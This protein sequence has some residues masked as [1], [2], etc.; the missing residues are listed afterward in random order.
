MNTV[1]PAVRVENLSRSFGKVHVLK[2]VDFELDRGKIY[3]IMGP[4]GCGKTTLLKSMIGAQ[5]PSAG[6]VFIDGIDIWNDKK[7]LGKARR[8]FG[9]LFQSGALLNGLTCYDNVALPLRQHTNLDPETIDIMVRMKLELVGMGHAADRRP[10]EISG[11]MQKRCA[12]AR[13]IAL[14]PAIVFFDEPSAGI[15]PVMISIL[16]RLVL[17]LTE[18]LGITSVV[19]THEIPSAFRIA[20]EILMMYQGKLHFRGKPEAV[21]HSR[22]PVVRQFIHGDSEGPMSQ[23]SSRQAVA[24]RVLGMP[25]H[26]APIPAHI[27]QR[28]TGRVQKSDERFSQAHDAIFD[29]QDDTRAKRT[30]RLPQAPDPARETEK[31]T[32]KAVPANSEKQSDNITRKIN[33]R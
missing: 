23:A 21:R 15:D 20:D 11:G 19:I 9:V 28:F 3:C 16:D 10:P 18:K 17:D 7:S 14:D 12:L 2:D 6:K 5:P 32:A 13:A 8:K 25:E 29:L 33:A 27:S 24:A 30:M 4:S 1:G 26:E 31:S 22:D